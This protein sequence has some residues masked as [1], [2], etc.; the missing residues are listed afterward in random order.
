[1]IDVATAA[2]DA[3]I[4]AVALLGGYLVGSVPT[5]R[6]TG[7]DAGPGWAFLALTADLAK[8]VLPVAV[9][10]VTWSWGI[11]WAAGLGALLGACWPR[12]G[13]ASG[14][15]GV[16]TLG[17]AAF[18]LAP[19]AGTVSV[20]LALAVYGIGRIARRDARDLAGVVGFGTF[21]ALFLAMH[22]DLV[23]L[24]GLLALYLVVL[25]R[26]TTSRDR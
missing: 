20:V 1:V 2:R 5:A 23:R 18:A 8:G 11:G 15:T 22:Q 9:G 25:V 24:G 7:R 14:G 4:V 21:P 17:G 16:A 6:F 3:V 12:F 26:A 13:R 10:V 19:P